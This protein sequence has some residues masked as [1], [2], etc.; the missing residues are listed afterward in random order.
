MMSRKWNKTLIVI[1]DDFDDDDSND[2]DFDNNNFN[3]DQSIMHFIYLN[4][5][6]NNW[7]MIYYRNPF[8]SYYILSIDD[9]LFNYK[10][11]VMLSFLKTFVFFFETSK[12]ENRFTIVIYLKSLQSCNVTRSLQ[13][14]V[15]R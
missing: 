14:G 8:I 2:N 5:N 1:N 12:F 4:I 6:T 3:N 9:L 10:N 15:K 7:K 11:I 13:Y